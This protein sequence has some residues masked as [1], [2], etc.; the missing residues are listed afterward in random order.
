MYPGAAKMSRLVGQERA[1]FPA[2]ATRS[3]CCSASCSEMVAAADQLRVTTG[4]R[5]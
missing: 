5:K 3:G 1:C 2:A 4:L